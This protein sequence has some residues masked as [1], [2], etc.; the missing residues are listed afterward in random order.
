[1]KPKIIKTEVVLTNS[2]TNTAIATIMQ[3]VA[4]LIY[5]DLTQ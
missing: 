2:T 5:T 1:M 4:E 3:D